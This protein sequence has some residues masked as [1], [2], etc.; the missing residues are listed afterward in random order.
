M[1]RDFLLSLEVVC[2]ADIP[3]D[4]RIKVEG[5]LDY[6]D[7]MRPGHRLQFSCEQGEILRGHKEII[8]QS[9]GEWNHPFPKCEGKVKLGTKHQ[10]CKN[11]P[12]LRLKDVFL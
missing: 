11:V 10:Y 6:G 9:N 4:R 1:T 7:L 12:V 2:A 5:T 3:S 8:C